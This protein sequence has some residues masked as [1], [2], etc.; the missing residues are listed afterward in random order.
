[1]C[2]LQKNFDRPVEW[3]MIKDYPWST[4]QLRKLDVPV[5]TQPIQSPVTQQA[6]RSWH[7]YS[8]PSNPLHCPV[9]GLFQMFCSLEAML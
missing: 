4:P 6:K 9:W 7:P 1:M 2:M 3:G 5:C 8:P